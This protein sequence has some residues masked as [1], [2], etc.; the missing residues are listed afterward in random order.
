MNH[1]PTADSA[2]ITEIFSSLQGEGIR[3][4]ER[5]I[6]VRFEECHIHCAYCDE[7]HKIGREMTR[8]EAFDEILRLEKA[9]GPHTYVSFTGGEPLMY[10]SFIKPLARELRKAGLKIYL[11]TNGILV[12]A[13]AEMIEECDLIAMDMKPPSV[14]GERNFDAEH[15]QFLE[16]ARQKETFVKIILSKE[17]QEAEFIAELSIVRDVAPEVP[18]VL[19]P[20]SADVEGHEDPELMQRL[21]A[22]QRLGSKYV[23]SVRIV[24]RFHK[25]LKIK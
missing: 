17:V 10:L 16:I 13:L 23:R 19:V 22:L 8:T 15:R 18:V 7:L 2:R 21:Q 1:P 25:I 9:E 11:E 24:P 5:H 3:L 14:T 20:L 6:F 4:G 12:P